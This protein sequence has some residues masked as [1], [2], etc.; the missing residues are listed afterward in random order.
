MNFNCF[1]S[2][3]VDGITTSLPY[4]GHQIFSCFISCFFSF[5][6]INFFVSKHCQYNANEQITQFPKAAETKYSMIA[7]CNTTKMQTPLSESSWE[8]T[9]QLDSAAL[10]LLTRSTTYS[11]T[12]RSPS[13]SQRKFHLV[14]LHGPVP[15][16]VF[17]HWW[18]SPLAL[19]LSL[20]CQIPSLLLLPSL[21]PVN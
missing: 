6:F 3:A 20:F 13:T 15:L 17:G 8:R 16:V 5:S 18:M 4:R 14:R 21:L 2:T 1:A 10:K 7:S 11:I 9:A 19:R 12:T